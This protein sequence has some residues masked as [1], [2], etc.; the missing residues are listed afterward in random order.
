MLLKLTPTKL[1]QKCVVMKA[2]F[3]KCNQINEIDMSSIELGMANSRSPQKNKDAIRLPNCS[4]CT[5][6]EAVLRDWNVIS[7]THPSYK[8]KRAINFLGKELKRLGQINPGCAVEIGLET[9]DPP[10]ILTDYPPG[11][12]TI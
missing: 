12:G 10:T 7:P 4:N 9:S 1:T 3:T 2:D 5:G 8:L 11:D 6:F